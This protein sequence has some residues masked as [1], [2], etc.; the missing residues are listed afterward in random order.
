MK[1]VGHSYDALWKIRNL[2]IF[3]LSFCLSM[4]PKLVFM[5]MYDI[6]N[7]NSETTPNQRFH[8][9]AEE[10]GGEL[11]GHLGRE[12]GFSSI[13]E[14]TGWK[15]LPAIPS[16]RPPGHSPSLARLH[17]GCQACNGRESTP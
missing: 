11:C 16:P 8:V 1:Y 4:F 3:I 15:E 13:G 5:T 2:L 6:C 17:P 10:R 7:V 14:D 12:A 9:E